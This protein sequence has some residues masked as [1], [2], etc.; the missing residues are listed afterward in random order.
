MRG[1]SAQGGKSRRPG[2]PRL[3]SAAALPGRGPARGRPAAAGRSRRR[4]REPGP[5]TRLRRRRRKRPP[6]QGR[7]ARGGQSRRPDRPQPLRG[8]RHRSGPASGRPARAG[9][10]SRPGRPQPLHDGRRRPGPASGR[11]AAAGRGTIR[12][13]RSRRATRRPAA[14]PVWARRPGERYPVAPFPRPPET[15][16]YRSPAHTP[17]WA[18]RAWWRRNRPSGRD[19]PGKTG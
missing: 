5:R 13:L 1:R 16:V 18:D 15:W 11:S 3:L 2:R 19:S 12:R 9:R 14:H 8:G 6:P 4:D 17:R 10:S 7:S